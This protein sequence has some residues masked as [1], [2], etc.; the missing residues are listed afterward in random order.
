MSRHS[1]GF[2]VSLFY[3]YSHKDVR[4]RKAMETSLA[5]LKRKRL[6][7]SWS[8]QNILPGQNISPAVRKKMDSSDIIVFLLSPAFI[9][10]DECIKEWNYAQ[11]ISRSRPLHRIPIILSDCAWRDLLGSDD[12]KA[13]PTDGRPITRFSNADTAWHDVYLGGHQG[14]YR[15]IR[16]TFS[17][18]RDYLDKM[19]KTDFL[20]E[21]HIALGGHLYILN[22]IMPRHVTADTA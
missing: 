15:Q 5:M 22:V 12:I 20:S 11:H 16:S 4:H 14:H 3:S 2:S 19:E 10:S 1:S 8:D 13:L 6:L 7:N 18:K 17:P 9:A 21:Q